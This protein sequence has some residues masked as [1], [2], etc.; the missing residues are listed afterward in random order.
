MADWEEK[1]LTVLV[2]TYPNLSKKYEELVCVAGVDNEGNWMRIY[3]VP[4]RDLRDDQK[5][6]IFQDVNFACLKASNDPRP[7]SHKVD[8]DSIV[9]GEVHKST[10]KGLNDR[11]IIVDRAFAGSMCDLLEKQRN[12]KT[13]LGIIKPLSLIDFII[14]PVSGDEKW[15]SEVVLR[16]SQNSLFNPDRLPLEE[17]KYSFKYKYRCANKECA[18]HTQ[19]ITSWEIQEAY[20]KWRNDK[21]EQRALEMIREKWADQ[22]WG[23]TKDTHLFVGNHHKNPQGFLVLGVFWPP[24]GAIQQQL[25]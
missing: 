1:E 7:E 15:D 2:K 8:Y 14:A 23:E 24:Q 19:S 13:S 9:L 4:Y 20:R 18:T 5:F 3:P 22:M 12:D 17:P 25:L 11:K 6:V 16:A 10:G 21:G